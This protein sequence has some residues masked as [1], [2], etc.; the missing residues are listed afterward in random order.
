MEY[1]PA[2]PPPPPLSKNTKLQLGGGKAPS[3]SQ[4][5]KKQ[6]K[7][8][9]RKLRYHEYVPPSKSNAKGGKTTPSKPP[10]IDTPYAL[11]LQQQQL[12]LQLQVLQQ[13]YP[14]GVLVQK[15]PELLKNMPAS[16]S[17]KAHALLKPKLAGMENSRPTYTKTHEIPEDIKVSNPSG[18]GTLTV[19]LDELKVNNLKMACKEL[20][21]I[22]SGKKVDLIERLLDHTGGVLP[23]SVLQDQTKDKRQLPL[24]H[25][26]S[27]DSPAIRVLHIAAVPGPVSFPFQYQVHLHHGRSRFRIPTPPYHSAA[28]VQ[29]VRGEIKG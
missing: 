12:F 8:K 15:L 29:R 23:A 21:L 24:N 20:N 13:Q 25:G 9:Y 6:Q 17:E 5:R 2:P 10:K 11:L 4:T 28:A 14:N 22:V 26:S 18:E 27:I 1:A 7:P 16:L 3:P 19:R